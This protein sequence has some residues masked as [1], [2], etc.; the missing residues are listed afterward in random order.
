MRIRYVI[1]NLK[2]NILSREEMR[3]YLGLLR[4]EASGKAFASVHG[5]IC[6]PAVY[7]SELEHLP[8]GFHRGAQDVFF[9]KSGA[10]TGE[11]SPLM[12]RDFEVEYVILGH[13]ERRE[14]GRETDHE[15]RKKT[16]SALK[17]HLIPIVC[18]GETAEER[19]KDQTESVLERQVRTLFSDL[20]KLQ[21][22]GIVLAYEPRWAIGTD[23]LPTSQEILQVKVMVRKIL[24]ELFDAPTA[25]R[26]A[27]IY[28]GSVKSAFLAAVS[29]ESGMDGVL[30]GRESLFPHEIVK[31]MTLLEEAGRKAEEK[32]EA[33]KAL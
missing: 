10:F 14:Y 31:M 1:G 32:K 16:L 22:E 12:L 26:V 11:I 33:K 4:R 28:G 21:A 3:Q 17:H 2:M 8:P 18:V 30:V 15:V 29:W 7:F 24:T 19:R 27:L 13:S 23:K 20:S 25:E 6:P 9:E 5:V